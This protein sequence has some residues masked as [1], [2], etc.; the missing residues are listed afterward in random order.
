MYGTNTE[1]ISRNR[2]VILDQT[3]R[4]RETETERC[5]LFLSRGICLWERKKKTDGN[6][7]RPFVSERQR[8]IGFKRIRERMRSFISMTTTG[9]LRSTLFITKYW[10][11]RVGLMLYYTD[12]DL[13]P[14]LQ[15]KSGLCGIYLPYNIGFRRKI[16]VQGREPVLINHR[17]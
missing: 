6:T 17:H 5:H 13:T 16:T 11:L 12:W 7:D 3:M 4:E 1:C 14:T 2:V 8:E 15:S 10:G 9:I